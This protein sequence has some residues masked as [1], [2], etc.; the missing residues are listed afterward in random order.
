MSAEDFEPPR[1]VTWLVFGD[2]RMDDCPKSP[3]WIIGASNRSLLGRFGRF[4]TDK[5]PLATISFDA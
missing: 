3:R 2:E 1:T 4:G 5:R